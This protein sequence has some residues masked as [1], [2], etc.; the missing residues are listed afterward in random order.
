MRG[1]RPRPG[2][3]GEDLREQLDVEPVRF[4]V[5]CHIRAQLRCIGWPAYWNVSR[6]ALTARS[7]RCCLLRTLRSPELIT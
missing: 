2:K 7:I 5:H 4:V 1:L 6:R 3:V